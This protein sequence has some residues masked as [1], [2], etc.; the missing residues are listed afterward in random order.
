[1]TGRG[2]ALAI[3]AAIAAATV[4]PRFAL[5]D[6]WHNA[7][8]ASA[9][10]DEWLSDV[11]SAVPDLNNRLGSS[12]KAG[13]GAE[14]LKRLAN[15]AKTTGE[16]ESQGKAPQGKLKA[17]FTPQEQALL[18]RKAN[19]CME[20]LA[21]MDTKNIF[22]REF[23]TFQL[24][25]IPEY[26]NAAKQLLEAMGP[27]GGSAIAGK[28]R[29]ELMGNP[30]HAFDVTPTDSYYNDLL[31]V[32]KVAAANGD[33]SPE[34]LDSLLE[35]CRGQKPPAQTVL[36]QKVEEIVSESV[37][38]AACLKWA[39][40]TQDRRRKQALIDKAKKRIATA[41]QEELLE[42][43]ASEELET[44]FRRTIE[45][46]IAGDLPEATIPEL[47]A[48]AESQS[49]TRLAQAA[50]AELSRRSPTYAEV[51]REV[52]Q[53]WEF[54][55][56]QDSTVAAEARRQTVNAFQRAPIS[57]CLHYLGQGDEK[58][59]ELIWEQV[60][61][62]I[63]RA[64]AEIRGGYTQAAV[65]VVQNEGDGV[66]KRRAALSLL[67]K[68]KDPKSAGPLIESISPLPRELWP[69]AGQTLRDLTGQDFGPKA[70]DGV[71]ELS[72]TLKKWREWWKT[73]GQR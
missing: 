7:S 34:E 17:N 14:D 21:Y 57:H 37:T 10:I 45:N 44:G 25:K 39:A 54:S 35:S 20:I 27:S 63:A 32:L 18:G 66:A 15:Q 24:E 9:S 43:L 53:I 11:K 51:Q 41:G 47:L 3:V 68:V 6:G 67:S 59:N 16:S 26:R 2:V 5:A 60:D 56:S 61:A 29:A 28:I 58:L 65:A 31:E 49:G 40:G 12:L 42:A 62:R 55:R 33:I 19:D 70:G 69:A 30:G 36:A 50:A 71:A 8:L 48:L 23:P 1:M 46:K 38:I 72:I 22:P 52:P 13:R 64:N 73:N 4:T